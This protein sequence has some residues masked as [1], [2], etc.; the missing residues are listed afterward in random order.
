MPNTVR[1]FRERT[2][3]GAIS[4]GTAAHDMGENLSLGF[5][6]VGHLGR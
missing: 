5:E 3:L 6:M 4:M 1:A 2:N